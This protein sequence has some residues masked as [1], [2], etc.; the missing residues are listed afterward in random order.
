MPWQ[1]SQSSGQAR[2]DGILVDTG[3]SGHGS[4]LNNPDAEMLADIGPI[5]KGMWSI[6]GPPQNTETHGPY[7]MKLYPQKGT[8]T[9]GRDGFLIHGDSV[10]FPGLKT[11]SHGCII[12]PRAT[13]SRIWQS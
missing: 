11:A 10:E 6:I 13:R 3:Y 7:V 2:K 5:P 12:M 1:Y 8:I 4:G 9:F